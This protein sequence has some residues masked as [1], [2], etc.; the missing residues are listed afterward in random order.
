MALRQSAGLRRAELEPLKALLEEA[1]GHDSGE[2]DS[3]NQLNYFTGTLSSGFQWFGNSAAFKLQIPRSNLQWWFDEP[4]TPAIDHKKLEALRSAEPRTVPPRI[5]DMV[6][7]IVGWRG[8]KLKDGLLGALGVD[9]TWP[10]KEP[11]R[12]SCHNGSNESH[13]APHWDCQCGVWAFKDIDRLLPALNGY[14]IDV[15][16]SVSLWGRVIETKNGYRAQYAYPRELWLLNSALEELGLLYGV[17]VR[18]T[19]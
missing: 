10:V 1:D 17:P 19:D 16:G 18:K 9:K 6:E 15:I 5:P 4:A 3:S 13:L 2:D 8:W 12:A 7:V 11:L 14:G